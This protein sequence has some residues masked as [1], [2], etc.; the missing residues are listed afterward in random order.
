VHDSGDPAL[1]ATL[2]VQRGTTPDRLRRLLRGDLETIVGKALKKNPAERYA[3]VSEFADDLRRFLAHEPIAARPDALGYR[4]AKFVRR[5]RRV[6]AGMSVVAAIVIGVIAFYTQR[7]TAERDRARLEAAKASKVSELLTGLLT[8]A[9]PYRT[10][11]AR[12]PTVQN[13][14]DIGA[15]RVARELVDQPELQAEMFTVIGR[16]YQRMTLS[17]KAQPLLEQALAI[18]R[19]T[20]GSEHVRVAQSLNDLGVLHR[21]Q[22]QLADA[23]PLLVES[24]AIRRRLLGPEDKDV[25]VTLVELA[26]LLQDRGR[27]ADAE[28]LAREA[29][30]IRKK[31]FGEEHR[32]TA[33]SKNELGLLLWRRG[34]VAGAEPLFRQNLATNQRL[35]GP[36]HPSTGSAM[37]NLALVLN[38][39][40]EF[41]AAEALLRESLEIDRR[42]FGDTN[43]EYA[44]TLN[45]LA[46]AVELQGRLQEAQALLEECLRIVG[47]HLAAEH[48]RVLVYE[49]NLARVRIARGEGAATVPS[50]RHV[51]STREQLYPADTWR[52]AQ[53]KSLLGAA[54]MATTQ[55]AEAEPLMLAADTAIQAIPGAQARERA[56]NRARLASLYAASGRSAP[57]DL[58]R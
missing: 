25:A 41:T 38:T 43:P 36:G 49:V 8:G 39:K 58:A 48:P 57:A 42:V 22:G 19:R 3:S 2:A 31:L 16:T 56:A 33:T 32:E 23:E 21:E 45:N 12:E 52:I 18:G 47:P 13:L 17:A 51:L 10:P 55:Y 11:D 28:P 30:T 4:A 27:I 54:L 26:R 40:G 34:D 15:E 50:L 24:L 44:S 35:L 20:W 46:G 1:A 37:S 29:L 5:H 9:D 6:L 7:L 14:L 53:A